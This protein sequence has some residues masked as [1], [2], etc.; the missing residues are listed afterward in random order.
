MQLVFGL[1]GTCQWHNLFHKTWQEVC[2]VN[3]GQEGCGYLLLPSFPWRTWSYPSLPHPWWHPPEKS[4][5]TKKG[6]GATKLET[7]LLPLW[8]ADLGKKDA[9]TLILCQ[10]H[11]PLSASTG[12]QPFWAEGWHNVRAWRGAIFLQPLHCNATQ[13]WVEI[14]SSLPPSPLQVNPTLL[15]HNHSQFSLQFSV[16]AVSFLQNRKYKGW[17]WLFFFFNWA[18][19][20]SKARNENLHQTSTLV[21]NNSKDQ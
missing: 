15:Y 14:H 11:P 5:S 2:A 1:E 9:Q 21:Q 12:S 4:S 8:G 19:I 13:A 16:S 10:P 7:S 6:I 18:L 3:R 17:V 20:Y